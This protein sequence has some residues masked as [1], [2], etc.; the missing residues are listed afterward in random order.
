MNDL[1]WLATLPNDLTLDNIFGVC[2]LLVCV[3]IDFFI[4]FRK[5]LRSNSS[6]AT[7]TLQKISQLQY[8]AGKLTKNA[9]QIAS[10]SETSQHEMTTVCCLLLPIE[11]F[12]MSKNRSEGNSFGLYR[13]F[14]AFT[15]DN[16][17]HSITQEMILFSM[18]I[19]PN[20]N[21]ELQHYQN[22]SNR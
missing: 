10:P 21:N 12:T 18:I 5:L 6:W 15:Q 16:L 7:T 3:E 9:I 20:F 14:C 1:N 19:N 4:L 22:R 2:M 13:F 17:F 8:Q 11:R